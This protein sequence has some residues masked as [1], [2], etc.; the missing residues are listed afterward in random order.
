MD[1]FIINEESFAKQYL[2]I[3]NLLPGWQELLDKYQIQAVLLAP[4]HPIVEI[5]K[6]SPEWKLVY[7]DEIAVI[8]QRN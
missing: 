7:E 1:N 5:L 2:T 6:V 4:H 8:L 3:V